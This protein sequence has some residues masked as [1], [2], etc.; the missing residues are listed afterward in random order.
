MNKHRRPHLH[1]FAFE[2]LT[3]LVAT[4]IAGALYA[5]QPW[6]NEGGV[7]TTFEPSPKTNALVR[8]S[9]TMNP[10]AIRRMAIED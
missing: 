6:Q 3:S 1:R 8:A 9:Q 7:P 4:L 10:A 2:L 5:W